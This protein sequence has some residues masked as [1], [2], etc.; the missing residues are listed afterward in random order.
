MAFNESTAWHMFNE[1]L[2]DDCF[3]KTGVDASAAQAIVN[4]ET[5][6][7]SQPMMNLSSFVTTFTEAE[8]VAHHHFLKKPY[9]P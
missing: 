6:T 2:P 4:S 1:D 5:W 3:P 8:E 9:R 7:D